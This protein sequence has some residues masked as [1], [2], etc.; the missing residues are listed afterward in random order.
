MFRSPYRPATPSIVA[1]FW[2]VLMAFW[3]VGVTVMALKSGNYG[4]LL[5]PGYFVGM[6]GFIGLLKYL[7]S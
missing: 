6:V 4:V 5:F 1:L 7:Q 2:G 3:V